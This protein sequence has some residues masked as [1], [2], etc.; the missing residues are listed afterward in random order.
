MSTITAAS[1]NTSFSKTNMLYK[2]LGSLKRKGWK[3]FHH[4]NVQMKAS[5]FAIQ[6]H[7]L[8][9]DTCT[10]VTSRNKHVN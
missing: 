5:T 8:Y 9:G 2:L 7:P 10:K 6:I 1:G 3:V 4:Y